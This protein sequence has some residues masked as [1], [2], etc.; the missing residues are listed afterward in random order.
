MAMTVRDVMTASP[1]CCTGA[2]SLTEVAKLMARHDCGEIPVVQADG[3][4]RPIGVITDRDIVVRT[5]AQGRNPADCTVAECMS[6]PVVSVSEDSALEEC[7]DLME[8]HQIRRVPVVDGKGQLVGIVAQADIAMQ[9]SGRAT[10]E[11]VK[12]VSQP[13]S[14]RH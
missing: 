2:T 3:D 6:K 12:Q 10:A 4:R 1:A 9:A 5:L 8:T 14:Q 13:D 11:V 7:C